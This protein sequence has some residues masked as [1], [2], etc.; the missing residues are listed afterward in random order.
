M[1]NG[2][3]EMF[4]SRRDYKLILLFVKGTKQTRA[5]TGFWQGLHKNLQRGFSISTWGLQ[6]FYKGVQTILTMKIHKILTRMCMWFWQRGAQDSDKEFN[7]ILKGVQSITTKNAYEFDKGVQRIL[8]R[9]HRRMT[10]GCFHYST[11]LVSM[12]DDV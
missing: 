4:L 2:W 9:I 3:L 11:P 6:D 5:C 7:I 12:L 8:T 1:I 10:R